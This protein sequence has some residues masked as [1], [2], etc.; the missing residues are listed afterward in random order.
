MAARLPLKGGPLPFIWNVSA[1]VGPGEDNPNLSTDVELV[2]VL[3]AIALT[4]P[5]IARFG[6]K[7]NSIPVTLRSLIGIRHGTG[8]FSGELTGGNGRNNGEGQE[9]FYQFDVPAGVHNITANLSFPNDADDPTALYLISPDGDAL[10]YGQNQ[11]NGTNLTSA[12]ANTI[13]PAPG[14]WTLIVDFA[15]AVVGNELSEPFTGTVAFDAQSASAKGL[16]DN[17]KKTLAAGTPVTVPVTFTNHGV[18]PEDVFLDP[19][20]NSRLRDNRSDDR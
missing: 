16:P 15:G 10:G 17:V 2:K 4:Q 9:A 7:G 12:A 6:L 14:R 3:L 18:A 11:L 5:W 13:N 20:L 19:R 8:S 1:R